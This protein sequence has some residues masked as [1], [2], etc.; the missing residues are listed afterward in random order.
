MGLSSEQ[1]EVLQS[2]DCWGTRGPA[3]PLAV[4]DRK[5]GCRKKCLPNA[6]GLGE[7]VS[8]AAGN[9][10]QRGGRAAS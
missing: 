3:E 8:A 9:T 5:W 7:P 6:L 4:Q 2:A 10:A 1:E